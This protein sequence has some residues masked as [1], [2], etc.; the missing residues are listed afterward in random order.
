M[1]VVTDTENVFMPQPEDLLV[2]LSESYDLVI[3]LLD[4]I[5]NY[6]IKASG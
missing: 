5:P 2:N 6:F 4:N 1:L 3:N